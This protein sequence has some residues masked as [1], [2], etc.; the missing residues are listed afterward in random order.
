[1]AK[2]GV[3]RLWRSCSRRSSAQ[4]AAGSLATPA[5]TA[6][7]NLSTWSEA[8]LGQ[9]LVFDGG[10][11]GV[12]YALLDVPSMAASRPPAPRGCPEVHDLQ[13]WLIKDPLPDVDRRVVPVDR[14]NA[15]TSRMGCLGTWSSLTMWPPT[16]TPK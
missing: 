15:V 2:A 6:T 10:G 4:V 12:D 13:P 9:L 14:L 3:S 16:P 7:D 1:M 8:A 11:E 5:T